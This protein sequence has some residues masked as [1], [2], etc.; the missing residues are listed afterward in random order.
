M[1]LGLGSAGT[2]FGVAKSTRIISDLLSATNRKVCSTCCRFRQRTA[3]WSSYRCRYVVGGTDHSSSVRSPRRCGNLRNARFS[4]S[5]S[6]SE[7][8]LIERHCKRTFL[9]GSERTPA[10]CQGS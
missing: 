5:P 1:N 8:Y 2:S 4:F 7:E 3:L 6:A 9:A 10:S